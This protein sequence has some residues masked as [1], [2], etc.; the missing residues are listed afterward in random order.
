MGAILDEV[1]QLQQQAAVDRK[2]GDALRKTGRDADARKAYEA[3]VARLER[4]VAILPG[5]RAEDPRDYAV[6]SAE[7]HGSL[8][9]LLRRLDRTADA[10]ASYRAG[11]AVEKEFH[12]PTTYSRVNEIKYA[13]LTATETLAQVEPRTRQTADDL[14]AALSNPATQQLGDD[15][16]AWAD[17]GDCR[18][19]CGDLTEATRAYTTF[20]AKAG[21]QAP[22]TT[23]DV[24]QNIADALQAHADPDRQRVSNTIAALRSLMGTSAPGTSR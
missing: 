7:T 3:G 23:L 19:L 21:S 2:R 11:A 6:R 18:G 13:L 17:L 14:L 4:C 5:G 1:K 15:G 24:L 20:I 8:G 16:W 9:G 22:A 10:F 12:L